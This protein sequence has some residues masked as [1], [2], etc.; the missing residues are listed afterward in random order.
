MDANGQTLDLQPLHPVR[1]RRGRFVLG[2]SGNYRGRPR[3]AFAE[4]CR[5]IAV[6]RKLPELLG[7]VARGMGKFRKTDVA[8]RIKAAQF[9]LNY[10]YH[11]Y[12]ASEEGP[13]EEP[14][15][16]W[17]KRIVMDGEIIDRI[18]EES[19]IYARIVVDR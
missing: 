7:E 8:T 18:Q 11:V 10:A 3:A 14:R 4:L 1:D 17:A 15:V 16:Q 12:L 19:M 6:R 9:L 13:D 2:Q 5:V